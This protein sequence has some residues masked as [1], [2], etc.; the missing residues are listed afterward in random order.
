M[1]AAMPV[2]GQEPAPRFGLQTYSLRYEARKDLPAT[3]ALIRQMGF[4]EV[5]VSGLY[6][7][8]AA[9]YR[10]LLDDNGLKAISMMT[11]Y[12]QLDKAV[13]SV[14]DDA[15]RLGSPYVV[16]STLPQKTYMTDEEARSG[17]DFLN[18]R[19]EALKKGNL[20][21]CYHTHGTEFAKLGGGTVFDALMKRTD[22]RSANLEMDIYW[23]VYAHQSP[24][25]LL[26]RYTGPFPLT[27]VKDIRTNTVLGGLP[28][29][30][31]ED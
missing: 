9:E 12:E 18:S 23:I 22:P 11:S 3:L 26:H 15:G 16:C 29:D 2:S 31:R 30:V 14:A 27:H 4:E 13:S 5:E 8:T 19:G 10:R 7:R 1:C 24:A 6:D 28:R 20:Q 21:F 25:T 17:A